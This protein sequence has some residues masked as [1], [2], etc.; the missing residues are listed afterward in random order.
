MRCAF[1]AHTRY[2]TF[3]QSRLQI[4]PDQLQHPFVLH[5]ARHPCHKH[6]VIHPVEELLQVKID[7]PSLAFRNVAPRRL[8]GLVRVA[9]GTKAV[10]RHGKL[11]I[12]QR[13][14]YLIERLLNQT[15][16]HR[17]DAQSANPAL[18][19]R[20]LHLAH[21]L[22][23]IY[24]RQQ[25]LSYP[26]PVP[27]KPGLELG[28]RQSI[29]SRRS[30]VLHHAL[31]G[32]EQVV[33][34]HHGFHQPRRLRFRQPNSRRARLSTSTGPGQV[35]PVRLRSGRTCVRFCFFVPHRGLL[36]YSRTSRLALRPARANCRVGGGATDF[37]AGHRPPLKLHVRFSRMQLSRRFND[38][39][40]QEK[41]LIRPDSQAHTPRRAWLSVVVSNHSY[42]N[43]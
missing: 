39:R 21:R 37:V 3:H 18:R 26:R 32:T 12:E 14:Q 31:I 25:V 34:F 28:D 2:P 33:A 1:R 9:S 15:V 23:L 16:Q 35:P 22:R 41:E 38:S 20:Y 43:A 29:D 17:R 11:R 5:L 40:M 19:L 27:L 8:H 24:A 36:S 6:V 10:A 4:A 7:D 13:L 30:F 42:A